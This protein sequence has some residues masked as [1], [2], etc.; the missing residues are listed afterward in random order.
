MIQ[1]MLAV[2]TVVTLGWLLLPFV[3]YLKDAPKSWDY[4]LAHWLVPLPLIP[5]IWIL[6]LSMAARG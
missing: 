4:A 1:F 6:P 5:F 2:N 3:T